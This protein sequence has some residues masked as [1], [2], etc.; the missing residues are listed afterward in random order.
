MPC[1][2]KSTRQGM[3]RPTSKRASFRSPLTNM[4]PPAPWRPDVRPRLTDLDG[5]GLTF[6]SISELRL[7]RK[8]SG[9]T[10]EPS[11]KAVQSRMVV[12]EHVRLG[13]GK[14]QEAAVRG[15]RSVQLLRI[16]N[17]AQWLAPEVAAQVLAKDL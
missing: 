2:R 4:R 11:R 14:R 3:P 10:P 13:G 15:Y 8:R 5:A 17:V 16:Q 9:D 7:G 6:G 1:C 12:I